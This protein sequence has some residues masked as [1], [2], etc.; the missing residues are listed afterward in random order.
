MNGI[1]LF[2]VEAW[3]RDC[4]QF[5]GQVV[6]VGTPLIRQIEGA[7][8]DSRLAQPNSLFV[9]LPGAHTDGHQYVE[10]AVQ[11]GSVAALVDSTKMEEVRRSV[12]G[13]VALFPVRDPLTSMQEIA[14]RWRKQFPSLKR[15]AVTGSNGKTSTK[16]M[17]VSILTRVGET[18]YSH[19]NYNSEIGLPLELL[20][21]RER[22]QFGVFELGMNK[23]GEMATLAR[24]VDPDVALITNIGTAHIGMLGSRERIAEEKREIF[25]QFSGEQIAI[26]PSESAVTR[27]DEAA[28]NG[29]L[30]EYSAKIAGVT[31]VEQH[32]L[33]GSLIKT[34]AGNISFGLAGAH[35]LENAYAAMTVG[36]VLNVPF[37]LIREGIEMTIPSFGR[38]EIIGGDIT[39][40]Q[41]CYNANPESMRTAIALLEESEAAGRR[42]A[43]L[44]A[45]KELGDES[46]AAH[47]A[48]VQTA[49]SANIDEVWL[50][51]AEFAESVGPVTGERLCVF[52]PDEWDDAVEALSALNSGDV[53]L[54]KGSRSTELE[55]LTPVIQELS[56]RAEAH[57]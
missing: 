11:R 57:K 56:S 13:S 40:I 31:G 24:L 41:D 35:M 33:R 23:V 49:L 21:I 26:V 5:V 22:H 47:R 14:L 15:I 17:I 4:K 27:I 43:I 19:G 54:L 46:E 53:V 8:V 52:L 1:G 28:I 29:S 20:R 3:L 55:R 51:G 2:A 36:K 6:V 25:S 39:I 42:I 7:V 38:T 16:E 18:V 48:I 12:F 50:F 30:V 34:A 44:G 9:A 32:G 37:D 45:M 10:Q